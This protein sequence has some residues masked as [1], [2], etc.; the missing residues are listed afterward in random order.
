[1]KKILD[2][3]KARETNDGTGYTGISII[4]IQDFEIFLK[5]LTAQGGKNVLKPSPEYTEY[6]NAHTDPEDGWE[7][8]EPIHPGDYW[9]WA[10]FNSFE[11]DQDGKDLTIGRWNG[12][13]WVTRSDGIPMCW[14]KVINWKPYEEIWPSPPAHTEQENEHHPNCMYQTGHASECKYCRELT[15][16]EQEGK[17]NWKPVEGKKNAKKLDITALIEPEGESMEDSLK[18]GDVWEGNTLANGGYALYKKF[19]NTEPERE[20]EHVWMKEPWDMD[21]YW[22]CLKC[23]EKRYTEPEGEPY[24]LNGY[25]IEKGEVMR[26]DI[27][28]WLD[29]EDK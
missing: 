20:C 9:L 8:G 7:D 24:I 26:E 16:T 3:V 28:D 29:R 11:G 13:D 23:K 2:Y 25:E 5:S 22:V 14:I 6:V 19:T 17:L 21:R 18:S 12:K 15:H 10:D 4:N 27:L 1:M